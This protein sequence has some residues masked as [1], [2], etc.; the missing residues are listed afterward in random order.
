MLLAAFLGDCVMS[1]GTEETVTLVVTSELSGKKK[2][3]RSPGQGRGLCLNS[4]SLSFGRDLQSP[5]PSRSIS[6]CVKNPKVPWAQS[7][8]SC[9]EAM[10]ASW[11]QSLARNPGAGAGGGQKGE[12][13]LE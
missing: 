12:M 6:I 7:R 8:A 11:M 1:S 3:V 5:V 2:D 10:E 4:C 9:W 13:N